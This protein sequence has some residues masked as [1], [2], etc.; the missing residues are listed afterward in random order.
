MAMGQQ[1]FIR[2]KVVCPDEIGYLFRCS[3]RINDDCLPGVFTDQ[4]IGTEVVGACNPL[5]HLC[6]AHSF[7]YPKIA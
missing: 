4:K 1:D 2:Y 3:A 6:M 5:E 7:F